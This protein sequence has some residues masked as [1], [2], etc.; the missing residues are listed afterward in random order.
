MDAKTQENLRKHGGFAFDFGDI[1]DAQ[2][3]ALVNA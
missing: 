2:K 3:N 1:K